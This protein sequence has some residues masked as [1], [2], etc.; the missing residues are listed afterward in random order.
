MHHFMKLA[1]LAALPLAVAAPV[2][3]ATVNAPAEPQALLQQPPSFGPRMNAV[4]GV[5]TKTYSAIVN[6]NGTLAAGPAGTTSAG[7]GN[8]SFQ[9]IFP[10]NVSACVYTATIGDPFPGVAAPGMITVDLRA[11]N[12]NGV[13]VSTY[14]VNGARLSRGFHLQV[15]C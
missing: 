12:A 15:Q 8:G 1:M 13:F 10:S 14:A 5:V 2:T 6:P 7:F 11:G 4:A 3:A 9:L